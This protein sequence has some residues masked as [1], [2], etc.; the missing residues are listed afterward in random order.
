MEMDAIWASERRECNVIYPVFLK[1][2]KTI[3][4]NTLSI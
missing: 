1:I 3:V 4:T 2:L